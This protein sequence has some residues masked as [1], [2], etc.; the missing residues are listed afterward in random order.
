[1]PR[2]PNVFLGLCVL[3]ALVLAGFLVPISNRTYKFP[4]C[5]LPTAK[6]R[7][8]NGQ[9][10]AYQNYFNDMLNASIPASLCSGSEGHI[11]EELFIL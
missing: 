2:K 10:P 3:V 9:K 8:I 7:L 1:M 11:H 4:G 6:F 5:T